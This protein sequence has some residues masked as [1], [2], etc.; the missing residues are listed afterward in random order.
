MNERP[1][2]VL[3]IYNFTLNRSF[4]TEKFRM[5]GGHRRERKM[6]IIRDR[7][8]SEGDRK[9]EERQCWILRYPPLGHPKYFTLNDN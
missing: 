1:S 8:E 6:I 5:C 2:L 7:G 3:V 9:T 4:Q